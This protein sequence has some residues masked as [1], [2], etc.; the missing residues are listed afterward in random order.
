MKREEFD[1]IWEIYIVPRCLEMGQQHGDVYFDETTK[2]ETFL[3]D[4]ELEEYTK[5]HY[6]AESVNSGK[7]RIN[8]YKAAACLMIAILKTKPL[9]KV[10]KKYYNRK[11]EGPAGQWC[12]N[13]AL[14]LFVGLSVIKDY[15]LK[16]ISNWEDAVADGEGDGQS[17]AP[18]WKKLFSHSLPLNKKDRDRWEIELFFLRLEGFSNVLALSHQLEDLVRIKILEEKLS[19]YEK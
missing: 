16:E 2:D 12:F 7:R 10:S 6:M 9:K 17:E 1:H 4:E 3:Y 8:R 19:A 13:E 15:F 11:G 18:I 5:N 14:A